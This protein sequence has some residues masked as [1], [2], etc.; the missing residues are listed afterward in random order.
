MN[1]ETFKEK[2]ILLTEEQQKKVKGGED[3]DNTQI[4]NANSGR[5]NTSD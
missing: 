2:A 5:S 4:I 1:F 3:R